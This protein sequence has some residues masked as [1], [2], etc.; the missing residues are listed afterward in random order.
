MHPFLTSVLHI[1]TE[2]TDI[3]SDAEIVE[4]AYATRH[5]S[6]DVYVGSKL[7][8][9][10][11]PIPPSASAVNN[12]TNA[13]VAEAAPFSESREYITAI[14]NQPIKYFVAHNAKFDMG[15]IN[16]N[17]DKFKFYSTC[18]LTEENTICTMRL[19]KHL[20]CGLNDPTIRYSQQFLRY[21]LSLDTPSHLIP[22]RASSDTHIN[23]M[24]LETLVDM[25]I[26]TN[27]V[28]AAIDTG[29]QIRD[30]CW[31]PIPISIWPLKGKHFGHNMTDIPTD[32]FE[33]AARSLDRLNPSHPD[34]DS[35]LYYAVV[36]RI[37]NHE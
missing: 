20:L 13:M 10:T 26:K 31:S 1:D 36:G 23:A 18:R 30:L 4:F 22:H 34:F 35:D 11:N 9:P 28:S 8:K 37:G 3:T 16:T 14:L 2:T 21:Y 25:L 7:F 24:L 15:V 19:A 29:R 17:L 32:Y 12:I 5:I 33:W 27:Q 6:G